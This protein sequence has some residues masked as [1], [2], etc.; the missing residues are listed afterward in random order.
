MMRDLV[1]KNLMSPDHRKRIFTTS[2]VVDNAG[3]RSIVRKHFV[4]LIKDA[5]PGQG[6]PDLSPRVYVLRE[7]NHSQHREKFLCRL[8]TSMF[9]MRNGKVYL[10]LLGHSL[11]IDMVGSAYGSKQF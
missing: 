9:A 2:E 1:F 8:K 7:Q 10:I 6:N 5:Q 4:C 3:V 11:K